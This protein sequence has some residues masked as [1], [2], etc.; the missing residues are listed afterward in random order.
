MGIQRFLLLP[1][2]RSKLIGGMGAWFHLAMLVDSWSI[3]PPPRC[4]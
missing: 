4:Q 2:Q 3:L 1:G